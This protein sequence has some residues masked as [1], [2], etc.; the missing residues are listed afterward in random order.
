MRKLIGTIVIVIFLWVGFFG[1]ERY[2]IKPFIIEWFKSDGPNDLG[3]N[4][5]KARKSRKPLT[6]YWI[7]ATR[8]SMISSTRNNLMP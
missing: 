8:L 7:K 3:K 2:D 5:E 6:P 4:M 1:C